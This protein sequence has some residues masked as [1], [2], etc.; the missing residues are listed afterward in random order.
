[1]QVETRIIYFTEKGKGL[2]DRIEESMKDLS[3]LR[4]D[5]TCELTEF[6][7]EA[8][9]E[10]APIVFIGAMGIAVR[11]IVPFVKDKL[12]DSPVVVMD[13]LGMHVIPI[14]SGHVG[15]ANE[16]AVKIGEATGCTPVIT[17][18]TDLNG[19]FSVDL[20]AKE[21]NLEIENREGIA[22]VSTK[23][24]SGKPITISIKDYPPKGKVDV[25]VSDEKAAGEASINLAPMPDGAEAIGF[26]DDGLVIGIGCRKD[27]PYEELKAFVYEC[28]AK[29]GEEASSVSAI[30][31]IDIKEEEPAIVNLSRELSVPL[32]TFDAE[33]LSRVAGDFTSSDFVKET[34]GVDNVCERAALAATSGQG[35]LILKKEARDGMTVSISEVKRERTIF[36]VGMGPGSEGAMS[37]EAKNVLERVDTIVGYTV[38]LDLLRE[39]FSHK[40]MLSTPMKK[41]VDRCRMCFEEAMKGK[42]VAMVC[43]GDAGVYGMASIMYEL[44]EEYNKDSGERPFNIEIIPGVTA[45]I[46][47][48]AALGAPLN[49]DFCII[50]LSDLLTPWEKIEGRLRAA[51]EGDFAIAIYNPSSKKRADYLKRACDILMERISPKTAC[52]Y[53]KN[54]EREGMVTKVCS[55][56]ELMDEEVDMFTTV[57]IGNSQTRI[58]DDKLVTP[59]GYKL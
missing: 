30:A 10:A 51:A 6:C 50:S 25:L 56:V 7:G 5:K 29:V 16:L 15:G 11:T 20:F 1:M 19:A 54:I 8:F 26:V 44:A 4:Y 47:G 40:E 18:A 28:L 12:T 3:F 59:R 13:E 39:N 31:T 55:L 43:S 35:R 37:I 38:Y 49:H 53:V 17:T 46:S 33:V 45:A 23:A 27:K 24:L 32:L 14:L 2:A 41:E 48:A 52:G 57:F 9:E 22:K 34:V 21:N 42:A 58:I 36:V